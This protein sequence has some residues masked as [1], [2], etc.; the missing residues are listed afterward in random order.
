MPDQNK[1]DEQVELLRTLLIVQL[2]LAN[3][4]HQ[5][6]RAIAACGMNRVSEVARLLGRPKKDSR[7]ATNASA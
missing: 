1:I 4:P 3:I 6:I 7:S 5:S 2:L